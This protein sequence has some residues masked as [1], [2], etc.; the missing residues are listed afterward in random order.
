MRIISLDCISVCCLWVLF[1][2]SPS[3]VILMLFK[4]EEEYIILL[5]S[6]KMLPPQNVSWRCFVFAVCMKIDVILLNPNVSVVNKQFLLTTWDLYLFLLS[7]TLCLGFIYIVYLFYLFSF[8]V[9]VLIFCFKNKIEKKK[10][11]LLVYIVWPN[12]SV[13][14]LR[15]WSHHPKQILRV[16]MWWTPPLWHTQ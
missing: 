6:T 13:L 8:F 5:Y 4:Y 12:V 9:F 10:V 11:W 3:S 15:Q 16:S 7:M 1:L 14:C 2:F